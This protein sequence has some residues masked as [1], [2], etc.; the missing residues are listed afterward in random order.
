M[1]TI[2]HEIQEELARFIAEHP[3]DTG[4]INDHPGYSRVFDVH[5]W[6]DYP[7]I[8]AL[9][10]DFYKL[11]GKVDRVSDSRC[12]RT[13]RVILINLFVNHKA[14]PGLWT[15][16]SRR[17][18]DYAARSRYKC[19][20]IELKPMTHAVDELVKLGFLDHFIGNNDKAHPESNRSS[21]MRPT[22]K[23]TSLFDKLGPIK[24][25]RQPDRELISLRDENGK[26]KEY[27]KS[28]GK[29]QD[30]TKVIGMR[31]HLRKINELLAKTKISCP[32][33]TEEIAKINRK[34]RDSGDPELDTDLQTLHRVF[35]VNFERGGR[36]YGGWW[37]V[38]PKEAR[39]RIKINGEETVERDYKAMHP[40]MLYLHETGKPPAGDPYVLP[41]YAG[42]SIMRTIVKFCFLILL[43]AK[44]REKAKG[45]IRK[46]SRDNDKLSDK[47]KDRLNMLDLDDVFQC[48]D[49]AH[50]K[51]AKY[52][53]SGMG[54]KLQYWD[55]KVAD[56]V[57]S[58][59]VDKG[60]PCLP[61]HDSFIVQKQHEDDLVEAMREAFYTEWG[62]YPVID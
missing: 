48:I 27:G 23:L 36:F 12:E 46:K 40:T 3:S 56:K 29:K 44:T 62:A 7:E 13:L 28:A 41:S 38:A 16:Y 24:T 4:V 51:I 15:A 20:F 33:T 17:Q 1:S 32:L 8:K 34:H 61:V 19:M 60:I 14:D 58:S 10:S 22:E 35:N 5:R 54:T 42:E 30:S 57:L 55:S 39:Q 2:T 43:N 26:N 9:T 50:P 6:S 47:A 52:I 59:L 11:T 18:K 21:R 45:A 25:Y 31:N 49:D 53:G 37:E